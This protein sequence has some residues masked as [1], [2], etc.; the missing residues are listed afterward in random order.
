M[1][2][3]KTTYKK[4]VWIKYIMNIIYAIILGIVQGL[5]EFLPVSSSGH[6][7]LLQNIFGI[8][9]DIILF[10]VILHLGTLVAVFIVYRKTIFEL[11]KKPFSKKMQYLVVGTIPTV[12]IALLFKDFFE[13][14]FSGD[15]LF[16]GF[17]ATAIL[18]IIADFCDKKYKN[19]YDMNFK[20]VSVMGLFQGF[21]IMPGLS[22]SGS[23]ITS[24]IVMGVDKKDA[25]EYSFLLSIPIIF[26]SMIYELIKTPI[27]TVSI[28]ILPIIFGFV[29][30]AIFGYLAIKF[31]I[32]LVQNKS[33]KY[34][35]IYLIILSVFLILNKFIFKLF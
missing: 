32:K 13:G 16:I 27:Q 12:I 8:K 19:K 23:T 24:A 2:F 5:T 11:I 35:S 3:L 25:L 22:R 26:A 10:D 29:F 30:S 1:N 14:A 17:L 9:N 31:M 28:G 15:F 34:F 4:N 7:V 33:Y 20:R 21:A 6:L 18:L